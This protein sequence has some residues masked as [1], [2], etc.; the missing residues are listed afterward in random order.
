MLQMAAIMLIPGRITG[1]VLTKIIIEGIQILIFIQWSWI[2]LGVGGAMRSRQVQNIKN[3]RS[4]NR[5][6]CPGPLKMKDFK[7]F[8]LI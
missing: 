6:H 8:T 4:M 2:K 7:I 5:M 1:D 3:A